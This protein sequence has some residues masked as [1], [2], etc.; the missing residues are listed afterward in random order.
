L[1][2]SEMQMTK[3]LVKSIPGLRYEQ[4]IYPSS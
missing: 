1:Y 3:A 4:L 2:S